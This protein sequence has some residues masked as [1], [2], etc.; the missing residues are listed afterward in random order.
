MRVSTILPFVTLA[1]AKTIDVDV[2]NGGLTFSPS[3][4]KA[5]KGDKVQFH[6]Y[7]GDHS[8]AQSSFDKPCVPLAGGGGFFSGFINP[9]GGAEEAATTFTI[10]ITSTDPIFFYCS[11]DSHCGVGMSGVINQGSDT[12]DAY[13]MAAKG[14]T[15]E[16]P[17]K[18]Q[19]GVIGPNTEG[20]ESSSSE[21]ASATSAPPASTAATST[22]AATTAAVTTAAATTAAATTAAPASPSAAT[23]TAAATSLNT[24]TVAAPSNGTAAG[25]TPVAPT[26]VPAPAP[27]GAGSIF[28]AGIWVKVLGLA[29]AIAALM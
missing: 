4:I 26:T 1:V 10:T 8:V 23:T 3:N 29:M 12:L 7:A 22:T 19:G 2:G 28:E 20:E 5:D 13:Q 17:S 14:A 15:S 21:A 16:S 24:V 18:V 6:F 11:Q 9:S 27:N 25:T